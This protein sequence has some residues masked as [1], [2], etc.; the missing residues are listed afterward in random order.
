MGISNYTPGPWAIC[1]VTSRRIDPLIRDQNGFTVAQAVKP[2]NSK[3]GY[4][5]ESANARL[6]AAAPEL[7]EALIELQQMVEVG[8]SNAGTHEIVRAAIAKATGIGNA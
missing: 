1:E 2:A 7:L 6:I 3:A 8:E 5:N 4:I